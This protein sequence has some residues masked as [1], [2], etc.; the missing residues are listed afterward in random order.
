M[1]FNEEMKQIK[2]EMSVL[3]DIKSKG[4]ILRSREQEIEEG[5]KCTRYF[6]NKTVNKGGSILKLNKENGCTDGQHSATG[7]FGWWTWLHVGCWLAGITY[8]V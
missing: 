7:L 6:F 5:E 3:A 1:D 8:A 2:T 4:V